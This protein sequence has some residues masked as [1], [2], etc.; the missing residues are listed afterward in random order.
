KTFLAIWFDRIAITNTSLGRW[1][2]GRETLEHPFSKQAIPMM[3]DFPE[4]NIFSDST[5]SGLNQLSW[6][7]RYIESECEAP[8]AV[9]SQNASSGDKAQF[10]DK[11]ITA[12]VTDP[13]YYDAIAYADL[14]DFFYVWLKRTI[15]D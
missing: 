2:I 5:G 13:P 3:Y 6:L 7:T 8:F 15:G 11:S 12:V 9:T 14:S 1:H 4:V 10:K